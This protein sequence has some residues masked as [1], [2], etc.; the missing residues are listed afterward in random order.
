MSYFKQIIDLQ[1]AIVQGVMGDAYVIEDVCGLNSDI[2]SGA[3]PVSV[4]DGGGEYNGLPSAP[5]GI[6][7]FSSN[8]GD[9]GILTITFLD[10][11][12]ATSYTIE[13][14]TLNGTTTVNPSLTV[15]RLKSAVYKDSSG[16]NAGEITVR[17]IADTSV[18]FAKISANASIARNGVF[19]IPYGYTGILKTLHATIDSNT[20]LDVL[21]CV[22]CTSKG[23][24]D[25]VVEKPFTVHSDRAYKEE[26][27]GGLV[28]PQQTDIELKVLAA[29]LNNLKLTVNYSLL[30]FKN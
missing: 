29:S 4:W 18:V 20:A 30:L 27:F 26:F 6:E 12:T 11:S 15:Y 10:N 8:A 19:F 9:T 13:N 17:L 3:L 23:D 1:A 7:V 16:Y 24:V 22:L 28:F 14:I 5:G 25:N 2:N 21:D